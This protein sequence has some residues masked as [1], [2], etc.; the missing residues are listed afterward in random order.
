MV[1]QRTD[2]N[3][4]AKARITAVTKDQMVMSI[5]YANASRY[6]PQNHQ[7]TGTAITLPMM[8]R[9]ISSDMFLRVSPAMVPPKT[10][11][12]AMPFSFSDAKYVLIA[13]SPSTDSSVQLVSRKE[14][15][16]AF[17]MIS[18]VLTS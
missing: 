15:Q 2:A 1:C 4:M 6:R 11:R 13:T 14:P 5:L 16:I 8:V 10:L 7:A 9:I 12:M 17:H 3:E 18:S